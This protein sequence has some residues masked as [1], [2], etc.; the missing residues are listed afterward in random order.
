MRKRCP[1][2]PTH[3]PKP[4]S[5][6]F[7]SSNRTLWNATT[8]SPVSSRRF[9]SFL[10]VISFL[11]HTSSYFFVQFVRSARPYALH[12]LSS[13]WR[14]SVTG[15]VPV[16]LTA[17]SFRIPFVTCTLTHLPQRAAHFVVVYSPSQS[18]LAVHNSSAPAVC[19][20]LLRSSRP[21]PF[22]VQPLGAVDLRRR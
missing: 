3:H 1:R 10:V 17:P 7:F 5:S 6:S 11:L 14:V 13:V 12:T 19:H 22:T 2:N 16:E 8:G 15:R 9:G 18:Y 4:A 21:L 20:L